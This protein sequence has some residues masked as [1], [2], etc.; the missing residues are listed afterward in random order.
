M[1]TAA[2]TAPFARR[3]LEVALVVAGLSG[4]IALSYEIVWYRVLSVMTRGLASTFGI[5][6]AVY[7][8]GIAVGS[9]IAGFFC[10]DERRE[11]R[12]LAVLAGFVA[13]ANAIAA[14]VVPAFAWSAK[15]TDYRLGL[16]VVAV[17]AACLGAILPL[18]SHFAIEPDER[19]GARLSYVYLAN[20]IGSAAGSL[21]TGFVLMDHLPLA[22]IARGLTIAGFFLASALLLLGPR[23][24]RALGAHGA[25]ALAVVGAV[26]LMPRLYDRVYERLIL[27]WADDGKQRFAQVVETKSGVITVLDDG[28]IYG[29]GTYDGVLN[30][31][32]QKNDLNGILRAYAVHAIHPAPRDVL[33]VGLSGGAWAQVVAHLP[34]VEKL[35]IVEINPG[36]V[37]VVR[38]HPEVSSLLTNPKV[39]IEFDDGRRWLSRHPG[40][41]FDF[42]V[43]NTTLHWRAHA[44]SILSA[45]FME[46]ARKH[47][48]PGGVFYFN[49]TDSY[50]VQLTAATLFPHLLR[51][52]N[53]IAVSE[54]P[55]AFDRP[56]WKRLFET[57]TIDGKPVLD[58]SL[59]SDRKVLEELGGYN[60]MEPRWSILQR[61]TKEIPKRVVT[62]DN[63][64]VEWEDPLL[65]PKP[66]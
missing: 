43:M 6:L 16:A 14:L 38:T 56:R 60:D 29:G 40:R 9:R 3:K 58:L 27:K 66:E 45:E 2:P 23:G 20:I 47:L 35:T 61:Y 22:S 37:E 13:V 42:I 49:T 7:L 46:L 54:G 17:G 55:F 52:A 19:A 21:F 5:L 41:K 1:P 48:A 36:Y 8:V 4:F 53:F 34:A 63:M 30:T 39:T 65:Y 11:S 62:D 64:V 51:I 24:S 44:T 31:Q 18:V 10:R 26:V 32:I 50:D 28:T 12:E 57:M 15:F 59:E 33:M 25:I